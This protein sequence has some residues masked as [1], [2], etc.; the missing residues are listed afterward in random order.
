M[1]R[2]SFAHSSLLVKRRENSRSGRVKT[3]RGKK[4]TEK[5]LAQVTVNY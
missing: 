2:V 3:Q 4:K 1:D 5:S